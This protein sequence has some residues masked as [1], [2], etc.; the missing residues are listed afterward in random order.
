MVHLKIMPLVPDFGECLDHP[1][2]VLRPQTQ[3]MLTRDYRLFAQFSNFIG[4]VADVSNPR[5]IKVSPLPPELKIALDNK[6]GEERGTRKDAYGQDI[7]WTFAKQMKK[8][9]IPEDTSAINK[10]V[11]AYIDELPD[12][13]PV[14]TEWE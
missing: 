2:K 4:S 7:S 1:L 6:Q 13:M 8:L 9:Q 11:K 5:H 3:L 12:D 14:I 10:A